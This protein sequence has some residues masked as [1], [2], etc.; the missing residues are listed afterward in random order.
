[1]NHPGSIDTIAIHPYYTINYDRLLEIVWESIHGI[2]F[3][4]PNIEQL[5]R[6]KITAY[7]LCGIPLNFE[8]WIL[9]SYKTFD[10]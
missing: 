9:H 3:S 8:Q 2:I 6:Q 7:S 4:G 5:K 10:L 1:M